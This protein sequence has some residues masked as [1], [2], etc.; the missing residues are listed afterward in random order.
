MMILRAALVIPAFASGLWFSE[1][2]VAP[3]SAAGPVKAEASQAKKSSPAM[4]PVAVQKPNESVVAR[5][6]RIERVLMTLDHVAAVALQ[7][8]PESSE[9]IEPVLVDLA[10]KTL[11]LI[12]EDSIRSAS[13]DGELDRIEETLTGLMQTMNRMIEPEMTL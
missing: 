5:R 4:S 2:T 13:A 10:E 9:R 11:E 3:A 1:S 8:N 7:M 12:D 6:L